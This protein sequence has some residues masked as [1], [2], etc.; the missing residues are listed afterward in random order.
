MHFLFH[1]DPELQI[2][3][4][5]IYRHCLLGDLAKL[6]T[7]SGNA[8]RPR[9]KLMIFDFLDGDLEIDLDA[10]NAFIGFIKDLEHVGFERE[11]S[12][13]LTNNHLVA[14][15]FESFELM[16][17]TKTEIVRVFKTLDEALAW[18]GVQEHA[19]RIH[20]IRNQLLERLRAEA[21]D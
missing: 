21:G 9:A 10:M 5:K 15:F 1:I 3:Y 6:A 4:L 19:L 18:G 13:V 11:P 16:V 14:S 7:S 12:A 17:D 8:A 2:T 20:E